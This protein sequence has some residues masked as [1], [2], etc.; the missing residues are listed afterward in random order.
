MGFDDL[1]FANVQLICTITVRKDVIGAQMNQRQLMIY[2]L[3]ELVPVFSMIFTTLVAYIVT[4]KTLSALPK[5]VL[6]ALD[7]NVYRLLWYPAIQ[8]VT[9]CPGLINQFLFFLSN[10][11]DDSVF[12]LTFN[13][14]QVFLL[15]SI[16]FINAISYG[17]QQIK[18]QKAKQEGSFE[19]AGYEC[20]GSS[21]RSSYHRNDR[22][23]SVEKSLKNAH[24][25][26]I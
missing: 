13:I 25:D 12:K 3:F 23:D 20:M 7:I 16:G 26:V 21:V 17:I 11:D 22:N 9:F 8:F 10:V 18:T 24:L 5:A 1:I 6:E 15:H 14:V 2:F 19:S 4:I